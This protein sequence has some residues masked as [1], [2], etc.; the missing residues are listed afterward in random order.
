MKLLLGFTVLVA[1]FAAVTLWRAAAREAAAQAAHPPAGQF[2]EV[3]GTRV[4]YID[5][6]DGPA[7]VLIHGSSGNVNDWTFDMVGRL[8]DRYRVIAFDRPGLGYTDRIG[9]NATVAQQANL[10]AD[11]A[12]AIGVDAP[13]VIGHSYG[14]AIALGWALER[15]ENLSG[16]VVLAGA[17]NPWEGGVGTYYTLLSNPV[18]GPVMA[19]L[20]V[21]WAPDDL[22]KRSIESVFAPQTAPDGYAAHFGA[23]LTLRRFSLFEN[24]LQRASLL[25]QIEA[26]VPRYPGVS[27]PTEILHGD[28]DT[29]V[30]L[31][32][33]SIPLSNQIPDSNLVVMDGVGHMPQHSDPQALVDAIDRL[34]A[35]AGLR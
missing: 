15:P 8:S 6:G 35:R 19:A 12:Q 5:E 29:T 32:V 3:N 25:P 34:A 27:V 31:Q 30:G 24:A 2:V 26:M 16:L 10:L 7:L 17:T 13:L 4:H 18:I 11:A 33:H 22:V 20:I 14:G 1:V 23:G 21:A 9:R 28:A